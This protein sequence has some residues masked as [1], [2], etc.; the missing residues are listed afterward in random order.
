VQQHVLDDRVGT[1]AML[2]NLIEIVAQRVRKFG[3][4]SPSFTV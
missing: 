3:N 1:L 2:D 4:F